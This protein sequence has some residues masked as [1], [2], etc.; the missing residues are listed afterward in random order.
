M[1]VVLVL[2]VR[3]GLVWCVLVWPCDVALGTP[4]TPT[5]SA[6]APATSHSLLD[7]TTPAVPQEAN[8]V[9]WEQIAFIANS[10]MFFAAGTLLFHGLFV[11]SSMAFEAR[12]WG[13]LVLN[14]VI[15]HCIRAIAILPLL[16][17]SYHRRKH[18]RVE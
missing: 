18:N 1:L 16:I 12:N 7:G 17:F 4:L 6:H 3:R 9:V 10:V 15:L 5:H 14:Y 2:V 11:A 8:H 13:Y